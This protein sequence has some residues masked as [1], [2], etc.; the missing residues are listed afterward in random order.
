MRVFFTPRVWIIGI[1][2]G[3]SWSWRQV[4]IGPLNIEWRKKR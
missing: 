3:W 2:F 4:A 1:A